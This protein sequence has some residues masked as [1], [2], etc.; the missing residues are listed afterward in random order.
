MSGRRGIIVDNGVVTNIIVW[1]DESEEQF[2]AEGHDRV[3]ETTDWDM[4]PGMGWTWTKKDGYR[5]P[6]PYPSWTWDKDVSAWVAPVPVPDVECENGW[7]WNEEDQEWTC[8]E[9]T[10]E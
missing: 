10:T 5:P 3:E 2:S 6:Q 7:Q 9:S 8:E 1:G 4:Q